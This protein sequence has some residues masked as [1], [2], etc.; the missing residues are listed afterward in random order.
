MNSWYGVRIPAAF[1]SEDAWFE[2]NRYGGWV[3][4]FWGLSIV[5]TVIVGML[6]PPRRW[7]IY[8]WTALAIILGGLAA[9][10][11]LIYRRA[12]RKHQG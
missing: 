7:I 9:V 12:D 3:L 2:I 6:F 1:A 5:A 11:A 10:I 8:N 4:F